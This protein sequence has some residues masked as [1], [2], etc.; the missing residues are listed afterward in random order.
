M[1]NVHHAHPISENWAQLAPKTKSGTNGYKPHGL[2]NPISLWIGAHA[3]HYRHAVAYGLALCEE[4]EHR[5]QKKHSCA[6][7]LAWLKNNEPNLPRDS[8]FLSNPPCSMPIEYKMITESIESK[9]STSSEGKKRKL[10]VSQGNKHYALS[11]KKQR[12]N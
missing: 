4:Y 10:E 2:R 1:Y 3:F 12:K 11:F 8:E 9:T 6:E 7:H 5:Y